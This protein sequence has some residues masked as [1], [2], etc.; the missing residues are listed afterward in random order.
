M[1]NEGLTY[2]INNE[3]I[4]VKIIR[5]KNKNMYLKIKDEEIVVSVPE[6]TLLKSINQFVSEN[7]S[8]FYNHLL[9]IKANKKYDFNEKFVYLLG[10]K[11][12]FEIFTGF[13]K[14]SFEIVGGMI[15]IYLKNGIES[16]VDKYIKDF[17]KKIVTEKIIEV[18]RFW[19]EQMNIPKHEVS[20]VYKTTS[21]GSNLIGK[22]RIS[23]SAKLAHYDEK[24]LQYLAIHEL[25]HFKE[26][27]HSKSFWNIVKLYIPNYKEIQKILKLDPTLVEE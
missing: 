5:T 18:Q 7:I 24:I 21:W 19:E 1:T 8:K 22:R 4:F 3:E 27:N 6:K 13:N 20:V 12:N 11:Y 16:E 9:L 25:A 23:Y 26:P 17:L 15:Y 14:K 2:I 10:K